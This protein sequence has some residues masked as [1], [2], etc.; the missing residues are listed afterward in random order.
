ML[1]RT[2]LPIA[3]DGQEVQDALYDVSG[4]RTVP[5]VFVNGV[6]I[7]GADG[8]CTVPLA[9]I[10]YDLLIAWTLCCTFFGVRHAARGAQTLTPSTGLVSSRSSLARQ[11]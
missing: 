4:S 6:Y 5:Q 3:A 7:G 1:N 8:K 10:N 11:E 2:A 9:I